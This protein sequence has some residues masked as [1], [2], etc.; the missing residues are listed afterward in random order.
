MV[1]NSLFKDAKIISTYTSI[2]ALEDGCLFDITIIKKEWEKGLF[3]YITN[4]L[5]DNYG[6]LITNEKMNIPGLMDLLNQSN[7]AIKRISKN[8]T[9]FDHFFNFE[10][11]NVNG[12][13]IKVYAVQNETGKFTLMI[14][15]DY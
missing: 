5:L 3:N 1:E 14:P 7:Q 8:Y 10:V 9:K 15:G 13:K 12:E 2:E 4:N 11:E 6:I